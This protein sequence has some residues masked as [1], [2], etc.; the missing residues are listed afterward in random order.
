MSI[1]YLNVGGVVH[2]T[3]RGVLQ[4]SNTYLTGLLAQ[5]PTS[6]EIFV[7]RDP[8]HFRYVLN[9]IRGSR[10]LPSDAH[11]LAELEVEADFYA[12]DDMTSKVRDARKTATTLTQELRR[13]HAALQRR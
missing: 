5:H 1:V 9:W 4:E 3:T 11:D 13:I 6:H 8:A 12:M 2:A 10:V 7:D